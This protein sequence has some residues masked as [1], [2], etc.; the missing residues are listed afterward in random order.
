MILCFF[1]I[2]DT[3]DW[4][5]F[6]DKGADGDFLIRWDVPFGRKHQIAMVI[7]LIVPQRFHRIWRNN[8]ILPPFIWQNLAYTIWRRARHSEWIGL[9]TR[10]SP[11][12]LSPMIGTLGVSC[13]PILGIVDGMEWLECPE[14]RRN[15]TSI[16]NDHVT[17]PAMSGW[18]QN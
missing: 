11:M 17:P 6:S 2:F 13:H 18:K 16:A 10:K 1:C 12:F 15:W 7:H 14:F 4:T 3:T 5:K 8:F 9:R